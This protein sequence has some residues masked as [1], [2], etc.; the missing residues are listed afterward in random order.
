MRKY[1]LLLLATSSGVYA[2]ELSDI[3]REAE[4]WYTHD[5]S[6]HWYDAKTIDLEA[7]QKYYV[8]GQR[9]HPADGGSYLTASLLKDWE[10]FLEFLGKD[11]IGSEL[12]RLKVVALNLSAVAIQAQWRNK[13]TDGSSFTTC[14]SYV[15]GTNTEKK[16]Q[17]TNYLFVDCE[18]LEPLWR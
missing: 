5:Y 9:N 17:F 18:T 7:I 4:N 3:Q 10:E 11:W 12:V 2:A 6:P 1:L 13:K 14:D 16:W 15:A 8:N